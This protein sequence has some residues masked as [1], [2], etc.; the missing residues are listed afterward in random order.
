MLPVE[1]W[2][3]SKHCSVLMVMSWFLNVNRQDVKDVVQWSKHKPL[4]YCAESIHQM[5][6]P[7][8]AYL[9]TQWGFLTP[10]Y[11]SAHNFQIG[12]TQTILS[13]Y[14]PTT[15]PVFRMAAS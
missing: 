12:F 13:Y 8:A 1:A 11:S 15:L 9:I 4:E 2:K 3:I 6:C 7:W 14:C 5:T 10:P